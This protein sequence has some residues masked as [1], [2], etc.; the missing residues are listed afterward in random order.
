[1]ERVRPHLTYANVMVTIVAFIVLGG[2]TLAA[3]GGNF[4]LGQ[5][6]TASSTTSL[7]SGVTGP[8]LKL[9]NTSTATGA[10]ALGLN[11]A[12]GHAPFSVNSATKVANLNADKLD[13]QDSSS[14]LLNGSGTVGS[15]N[16]A[17]GA[18][19]PAKFGTI[20]AARATKTTSQ[21]IPNNQATVLTFD[22]EDFDTGT[23][24]GLHD[25]T[26][27]TRL[28]APISGVYQIDAGLGWASNPTGNRL[29]GLKL[30]GAALCCHLAESRMQAPSTS[31]ARQNVSDLVKLSAGD[32]VEAVALQTSGGNLDAVNSNFST[33]LAMTWVGPG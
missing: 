2:T 33:F 23:S 21:S 6:N 3:T 17:D 8:A 30:N 5:S 19:T 16:L 7:S 11:V 25:P 18:V 4:I 13:G 31:E 12:S 15:T 1:M 10:R 14:F 9:S 26:S 29:F 28:T 20:P 32:F 27:N 22:T 24:P